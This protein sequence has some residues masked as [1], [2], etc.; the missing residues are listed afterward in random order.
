MLK[1]KQKVSFPYIG[2][3]IALIFFI[4]FGIF[5]YREKHN[6]TYKSMVYQE[7]RSIS[8]IK[9][10][11]I[12]RWKD[13]KHK[14]A[15]AIKNN[16]IFSLILYKWFSNYNDI[17]LKSELYEW[18]RLIKEAN[19]LHGI[20]VLNNKGSL[21]FFI[22]ESHGKLGDR[23]LK[24]LK[25]SRTEDKIL[26][27]DLYRHQ[28]ENSIEIDIVVP[29]RFNGKP[30]GWLILAID[31]NKTLYPIIQAFPISSKT[32][33]FILVRKDG[34][35]VLFLNDLK[36]KKDAA[37]NLRIPLTYDNVAEVMAVKGIHG[38]VEGIDYNGMPIIAYLTT[39]PDLQWFLV[40]KID[41]I[42]A[43]S[44]LNH[45]NFLTVFT[46][47][48]LILSSI[49]GVA[50]IWR[51]QRSQFYKSQ[52]EVEKRHAVLLQK[53]EHLAKY[54]NDII[55]IIDADTY[56][57]V[58]ANERAVEIYGYTMSELTSMNVSDLRAKEAL[59]TLN[60]NYSFTTMFDGYVFETTH[61]KKN[62][63]TFP[64]EVSSRVL[65]IDNK[66]FYCSIVRDI[67]K[68]KQA[69]R[70]LKNALGELRK[71]EDIINK[72]PA[73]AFLCANEEGLPLEFISSNINCYGHCASELISERASFLSLLHPE[74]RTNFFNKITDLKSKIKSEFVI[75]HMILKKNGEISWA[76]TKIWSLENENSNISHFQ[77]VLIDIT[78]RK[79]LQ[80]Q[81]TQAQKMEAV[82]Q[83]A[84]GVAHD[85]NN[86]LTA[87]IGYA[88]LIKVIARHDEKL[89]T[90]IEH[91]LR[92]SE[93]AANLTN[94]LLT[95][96]RK[97][98][99]NPQPLSLNN[100]IKELYYLLLRLITEDI[101]LQ[102][103][104]TDKELVIMADKNQIEQVI[105]NLVTN[106]KD[107]IQTHGIITIETDVIEID[108]EYIKQHGYGK[109][110][111]YALMSITDSGEGMDRETQKRIFEPFFTTKEVG[112]GTGLGLSIVYGIVK[113]HNGYI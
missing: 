62:G 70:S 102:L 66:K 55:L 34:D 89:N 59:K 49:F 74:D 95:F 51:H 99:I 54:A 14:L 92:S 12:T 65:M 110:G 93:K 90:Y 69:E 42:E 77:G 22:C 72:S 108:N 5:F 57:I 19:D 21:S 71:L 82:G 60:K 40:T 52:Y 46:A 83:L 3:T 107:A 47:I 113:Q 6:F 23:T 101:D 1:E 43:F 88:Q 58:E 105:M 97:K 112:K 79:R 2:I 7:L 64:V 32:G 106:A 86:I 26:F 30:L 80:E 33:E 41:K 18:L 37:L 61:V 100:L 29:I 44:Y 104:L 50:F 98:I 25:K 39:I 9:A 24:L 38:I 11:E 36:K 20:F 48:F 73:I 68:R 91:I 94:S 8:E 75:E 10:A 15:E 67:T 45:L 56:N 27:S 35:S 63:Q 109:I 4:I 13:E 31:P 16:K 96:S 84:G 78:E 81:L 28:D 111:R 53:Y 17:N 103:Y 76:E 87:I 85:F